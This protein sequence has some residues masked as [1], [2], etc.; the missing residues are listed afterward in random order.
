M[1]SIFSKQL[2]RTN[3]K[4]AMVFYLQVFSRQVSSLSS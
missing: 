3:V 1:L 4:L 2:M